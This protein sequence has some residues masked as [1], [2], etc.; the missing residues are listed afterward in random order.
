MITAKE[1]SELY[2]GILILRDKY[3]SEVIEPLIK[4]EAPMAK[5]VKIEMIGRYAY[6]CGPMI[7]FSKNYDNF[8]NVDQNK[9]KNADQNKLTKEIIKTLKENGYKIQTYC[10]LGTQEYDNKGSLVIS[11][12]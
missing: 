1:A 6:S 3:I 9:F 8:K 10:G 11:W 7:D 5:Q 4:K 12:D 2:N